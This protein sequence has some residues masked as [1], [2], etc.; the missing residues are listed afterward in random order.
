MQDEDERAQAWY[1]DGTYH[2]NLAPEF[3]NIEGTFD[4]VHLHALTHRV[5]DTILDTR[6]AV[7]LHEVGPFK[8]ERPL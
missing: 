5:F 3:F 6:S 1:D 4:N 7:L 2:L 8:L